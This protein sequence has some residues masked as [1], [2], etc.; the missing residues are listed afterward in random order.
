MSLF[1]DRNTS[2]PKPFSHLHWY[3]WLAIGLSLALTFGAWFVTSQ[4]VKQK[5]RAQFEYQSAQILELVKERM[6]KYEEALW[7]GVAAL[8]MLNDTIATRGDWK[9]FAKTLDIESRFPG[10][11]GIGVIHY[12]PQEKLSAYLSWQKKSMPGYHIHPQSEQR[13]RWPIAY[14]EPQSSN[15]KAVG[16]DMGY[17]KNRYTGALK[18]RDSRKATITAPITLVQDAQ[19][20]PGFLFYAPWY[21]QYSVPNMYGDPKSQF[22]GLVYAPFIMHKL[23]SGTLANTNRQV[24]FSIHD[25]HR[26]LY[27]ELNPTSENYDNDP[28]YTQ[29]I[30][31]KLYGRPWTFSVQSSKL[32]HE[33]HTQNQP[34]LILMGG[35][36]IDLL[37]LTIFIVLARAN[38]NSI[39]YA[40]RVTNDLKLRQQDLE[41]A[42]KRVEFR[43]AE[44]EEANRE[45]DQF[46]FVASHDLKAPLRGISQLSQWIGEDLK[47]QLTPQ[48]SEYIDLIKSRIRRL[49]Q[50]LDDLLTYSRVGRKAGDVESFQVK[51]RVEV[52]FELLSPP[53]EFTL[54]CDDDVKILK[55]LTI[56][57]EQIILNLLGNSIKHHNSENG[58]ISISVNRV[59]NDYNFIIED[60]GPG[61]PPEHQDRVFE[62]FHT[63]K[64]RDKV[65][66]S[67]LGLSII[68]KILD[69]YACHYTL[70]S[71]GEKGCRFSFTWPT[72]EKLKNL[73]RD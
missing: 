19:K 4:Q 1:V 45:L 12:L 61:I 26:E 36:C 66:G 49:E 73:R 13:G 58:I 68:K 35:L 64:P 24:N 50:L 10:I 33:Q 67:G 30:T 25:G 27:N 55:T 56:P 37:L 14:I 22:L 9:R 5:S 21:S 44:L 34:M 7:A 38:R 28:M 43:N 40:D 11:N 18:A 8:H 60:D 20:T 63:L 32:F 71:D 62:L 59:G 31:L 16:L 6:S 48:T 52:L 47:Q 72:E 15:L 42:Q 53:P 39:N 54:I 2:E 17:E 23:M 3:H 57:L 69:R 51:E 41:I 70:E 29:V 65:E 46:A